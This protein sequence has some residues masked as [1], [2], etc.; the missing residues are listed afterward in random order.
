MEAPASVPHTAFRVVPSQVNFPALE[1][2]TLALWAKSGT[3]E[4][5][6]AQRPAE[7]PFIFYDGPP[8]ASGLPHYGHLLQSIIKDVVPRYW[9]MRGRRVE[10]RFGWDCHGL[11]VENEAEQQ[12]GLKSRHD[13]L[14]YGV[15][16][17][18]EYCRS[19]VLRY[20]AEWKEL[21]QRIGRWVDWSDTYH[22]MDPEFMESVWWVFKTLWDRDLI[23]E[24][25]RSLAYCPRCA[26]SLSN[27]EVNQGYQDTQDPSITIRFRVRGHEDL[28]ILA[29]TTT[30]WTLP[31]NMALAVGTE[32]DY[33][34]VRLRNGE[35]LI[36]ARS[37]LDQV[38]RKQ[39]EEISLVED[40]PVDELLA[41][42]YEPLFDYFAGL[43]DEGAFRVVA[44]DFVSTDSGTGIVH[45]APG[46]GEED[47]QLGL[48]KGLP[49]I[50]PI[51]AECRFTAEV[52]DYAGEFVKD[53]DTPI[54]RRLRSS[55]QLFAEGSIVHSYPFCWRCDS[56]LIYRAISTWFVNVEQIKESMLAANSQ[57]WWIPEHIRE[58]RFG[59]WLAGAR[60]WNIS[61]QRYW[62]T[63]LPIWRDEE[64]GE[65]ICVGS[66]A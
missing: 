34:R 28:S 44:A 48:R 42:T 54:I 57:I 50:C 66:R 63:P 49:V 1:E 2:E 55:E 40:Q 19:L 59:K 31:S 20:T 38:F 45:V 33:A 37:L 27:F 24:G 18:N 35:Q 39:A 12:L 65:T 62:G 51:D 29:W 22:T 6:V 58:G 60:D 25:Y 41:M 36:V 21:I 61:R 14:E 56:P 11:P 64:S 23:Y 10:R 3:F 43:A 47:Y 8:F 7:N 9:T 26:T 53:T 5:S 30:P 46:F 4:K 17:F 13:V 16:K 32:I 52:G 15:P